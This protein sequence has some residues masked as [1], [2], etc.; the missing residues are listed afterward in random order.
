MCRQYFFLQEQR[1][2]GGTPFP[3][4]HTY[5]RAPSTRAGFEESEF[6]PSSAQGFE[7][8][9]A[10]PCLLSEKREAG[11]ERAEPWLKGTRGRRQ[12]SRLKNFNEISMKCQPH[13]VKRS[14][15]ISPG[16]PSHALPH[17]QAGSLAFA[18]LAQDGYH[19][20]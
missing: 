2:C 8:L 16:N 18:L 19:S 3:H 20:W 9:I 10:R 5:P 12:I 11:G 17:Q 7:A 6:T 1:P 13:P 15:S 14:L 4:T